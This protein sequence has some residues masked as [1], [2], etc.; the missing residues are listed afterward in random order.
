M[1]MDIAC[2]A[3]LLHFE[4][5]AFGDGR[6]QAYLTFLNE[7]P[8]TIT[9]LSGRLALLDAQGN[10]VQDKRVAF[11]QIDAGPGARFACHLALDNTQPFA[12]ASM[13]VEDVLFDGQDPW[14]L[15]PTRLKDYHPP[16]LE[17]GP[18]RV[19][20]VSI[21]GEDAICFPERFSTTWVCVC[22]RFNRWRW[23][24]CRRC[25]RDRDKTLALT[26][27]YVEQ[28][29]AARVREAQQAPP[30]V[31]IDG[32]ARRR[33][34]AAARQAASQPAQKRSMRWLA[35]LLVFAVVSASLW[36]AIALGRRILR[37]QTPAVQ[38]NASPAPA[39]ETDF[40]EP[41]S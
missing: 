10:P 39:I 38:D 36:G 19:A 37:G 4:Q 35:L 17:D 5:T 20:L 9:A 28:R 15:H 18:Q 6:R 22:G 16:V 23:A 41:I 30:Q 26:P 21:A 25:R 11:G 33:K 1:K 12:S 3:E 14:A 29:Y 27:E 2:P 13:L 31:V 24:A 7:S 32:A 40:L 34:N 8:Y